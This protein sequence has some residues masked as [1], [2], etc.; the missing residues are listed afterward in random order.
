LTVTDDEGETDTDTLLVEIAASLLPNA[1]I[2][3]D[4]NGTVGQALS[5]DGSGSTDPDGGSIT[6]Y[7]W[8]F[9]DGLT[10]TGASATHTFTVADT[11]TVTLTVTDDDGD[12]ASNSIIVQIVDQT[13]PP[14]AA[15]GDDLTVEQFQT[16]SVNGSNSYDPDGGTLT[17][18]WNFGDDTS[19]VTGVAP[20]HSYDN[21]GTYTVTL[22]V[23]DDEADTDT[24]TL[25]VTVTAKVYYPPVAD[26]IADDKLPELADEKLPVPVQ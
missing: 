26:V 14:V 23:T 15:A 10:A 20:S 19:P 16:F 5:F 1:V 12:S 11:Y 2:D 13:F 22:T 7:A 24:D 8:D 4:T 3:G 18:S 21:D 17:Y 9:G 6:A 25:T